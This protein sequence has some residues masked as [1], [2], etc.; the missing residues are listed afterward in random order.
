M[1]KS[2]ILSAILAGSLIVGSVQADVTDILSVVNNFK[3][4]NDTLKTRK[5]EIVTTINAINASKGPEKAD[6]I[7]KLTEQGLTFLNDVSKI[8]SSGL[9]SLGWILQ[10]VPVG[11]V[12]DAGNTLEK[13]IY[14]NEDDKTGKT[15]N[16]KT[17][18]PIGR[19]LMTGAVGS[20]IGIINQMTANISEL[21]KMIEATRAKALEEAKQK[22]AEEKA[23]AEGKPLPKPVVSKVADDD[24]LF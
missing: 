23:I 21:R 1:K 10:Q 12:K 15:I 24:V 8:L 18:K 4:F 14:L 13:L 5:T 11:Q 7:L 6:E 2:I 16:P 17:G 3:A 9:L 22:E 20:S 19:A